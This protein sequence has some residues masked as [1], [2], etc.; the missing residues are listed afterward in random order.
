MIVADI[1]DEPAG[2]LDE[3][4]LLV[5]GAHGGADTPQFAIYAQQPV[6][7]QS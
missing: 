7:S 6:P 5:V 2:L 3:F 4:I 1:H